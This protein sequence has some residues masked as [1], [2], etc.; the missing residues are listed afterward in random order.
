[1]KNSLN[2]RVKFTSQQMRIHFMGGASARRLQSY[3]EMA[4]MDFV[5]RVAALYVL[6]KAEKWRRY[7][8][9]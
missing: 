1:M 4:E 3:C 5:E 9:N 8:S 7:S 2:S 6:W